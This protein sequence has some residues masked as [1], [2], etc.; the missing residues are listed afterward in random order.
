MDNTQLCSGLIL[1]FIFRDHFGR[2][3]GPNVVVGI[4]SGLLVCMASYNTHYTITVLY[5]VYIT[6]T[7]LSLWLNSEMYIVTFSH[8]HQVPKIVQSWL[9]VILVYLNTPHVPY[10]LPLLLYILCPVIQGQEVF[11]F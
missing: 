11:I 2:S 1:G 10:S 5:I 3:W 4:E 6:C 7:V 9:Y 8:Y